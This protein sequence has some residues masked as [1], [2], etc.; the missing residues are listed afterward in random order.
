MLI[1]YEV[2]NYLR[3]K[4]LS[5]IYIVNLKFTVLDT[6]TVFSMSCNVLF[7][8]CLTPVPNVPDFILLVISQNMKYFLKCIFKMDIFSSGGNA[9]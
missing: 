6:D 8:K 1:Y 2:V 3:L 5:G 4:S 9:I 7:M